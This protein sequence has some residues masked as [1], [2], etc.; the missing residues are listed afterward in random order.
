M[1]TDRVYA[2][3]TT[4]GRI[5]DLQQV[6][7]EAKICDHPLGRAFSSRSCLTLALRTHPSSIPRLI[8]SDNGK[9][10]AGYLFAPQGRHGFDGGRVPHR[11]CARHTGNQTQDR[12]H[13]TRIIGSR[14]LPFTQVARIVFRTS[15][16]STWAPRVRARSTAAPFAIPQSQVQETRISRRAARPGRC[17]GKL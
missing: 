4:R 11:D 14:E 1:S 3:G 10:L 16:L 17:V 13:A 12:V 6:L 7:T 5:T 15:A 9:H 2:L 8:A